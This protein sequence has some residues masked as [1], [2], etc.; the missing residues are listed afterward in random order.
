M[1]KIEISTKSVI[2]A[3]LFVV[4][5]R[6]LSQLQ[7]ILLLVFV[8]FIFMAALRPIV[9]RLHRFKVPR[10]LGII[11]CYI[12]FLGVIGSAAASIIPPIVEQTTLLFQKLPQLLSEGAIF[13]NFKLEPGMFNGQLAQV[14]KNIFQVVLSAFSNILYLFTFLVFTAYLILE[15]ENINDYLVGF[16]GKIKASNIEKVLALIER[17]VGQWVRGELIL[18]LI[19]GLMS[20]I[21][22]LLL[23]IPYAAPLALVAGILE[24][25]PNLGPVVSAV[26]AILIAFSGSPVTGIAVIALY[27]L[28]Q[29]LENNLIV[30]KVMQQVVG[31]R[32]VVTLLSLMV[33]FKLFGVVGAIL[34]V[35]AVLTL[36][37]IFLELLDNHRAS[38][39]KKS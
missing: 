31:L 26:P 9:E 25:V 27:T 30:P 16:F 19:V 13:P 4:F 12:L 35:P 32:P 33:G 18:M 29:Q 23:G 11:F 24:I 7:D 20:Y 8:A 38:S 39:L 14:P 15:R 2:F 1:Q 21:G 36:E 37:I 5:L 34:S 17:K 10:V 28:I 6:F 3:V 22:L